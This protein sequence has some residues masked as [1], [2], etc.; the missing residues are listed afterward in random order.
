MCL[1]CASQV[2]GAVCRWMRELFTASNCFFASNMAWNVVNCRLASAQGVRKPRL[3][4]VCLARA[5]YFPKGGA[6]YASLA[7]VILSSCRFASNEAVGN[8]PVGCLTSACPE[9]ASA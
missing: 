4:G 5:Q 7:Q 3:S 2:G 9:C 6:I 1:V 8:L